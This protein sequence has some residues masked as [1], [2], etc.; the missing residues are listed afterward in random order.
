MP[1]KKGKKGSS[2]NEDIN[3]SSPTSFEHKSGGSRENLG[4]KRPPPMPDTDPGKP[5]PSNEMLGAFTTRHNPKFA[6]DW[7]DY[8]PRID[9][10]NQLIK[11]DISKCENHEALATFQTELAEV[12]ATREK[13][14]QRLTEAQETTTTTTTS[15][16]EYA[17][18]NVL[19]ERA[20]ST[21]GEYGAIAPHE[22]SDAESL[23]FDSESLIT[24]SDN[25]LKK[26]DLDISLSEL[27]K[28]H[29]NLLKIDVNKL[30]TE[31]AKDHQNQIDATAAKYDENYQRVKDSPFTNSR[32][33]QCNM[34]ISN[35][36]TLKNTLPQKRGEMKEGFRQ[37][38]DLE[39]EKH[40]KNVQFVIGKMLANEEP[41]DIR[42][43]VDKN[44]GLG[45]FEQEIYRTGDEPQLKTLKEHYNQAD[46]PQ[47]DAQPP[48]D[49][50]TL[51]TTSATTEKSTADDQPKA[52]A[53]AD[54]DAATSTSPAAPAATTE[55]A[56]KGGIYEKAGDALKVHENETADNELG[57]TGGGINIDTP[58]P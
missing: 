56:R 31:Q 58:H 33:E 51:T 18:V 45:K 1:P 38:K 3:I 8:I 25:L 20:N 50:A 57:N 44:E 24:A 36:D 12:L 37:E 5:K 7:S 53:D 17:K 26:D 32:I 16:G 34:D 6:K 21:M 41:E 11:E 30:D 2:D 27:F 4:K 52:D 43:Y 40:A 23:Q 28:T 19:R 22:L 9:D 13:D 15:T 42:A 48:A 10:L 39:M 54:A 46:E 49:A 47:A 55:L 29:Q 14:L 35:V